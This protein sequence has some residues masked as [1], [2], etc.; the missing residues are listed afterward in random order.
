MPV[1]GAGGGVVGGRGG[2]R[3]TAHG[4]GVPATAGRGG[5]VLGGHRAGDGGPRAAL[6]PELDD[7]GRD[8]GGDGGRAAKLAAL[9]A[10][11]GQRVGRADGDELALPLGH[12][13]EDGGDELTV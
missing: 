11:H 10:E 4:G 7:A 9:R 5:P 13:G 2:E 3:D 1:V 6:G 12:G 8:V